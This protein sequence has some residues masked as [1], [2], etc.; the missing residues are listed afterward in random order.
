MLKVA[1]IILLMTGSIGMGLVLKKEAGNHL[2]ELYRFR[3]ILQMLQNEILYH[4]SPLPEACRRI[5][6]SLK[7][8]YR[9]AFFRIHD[10]MTGHC[11]ENFLQI[12]QKHM[13]ACLKAVKVSPEEKDILLDLG[14]CTAYSDE[15]AQAEAMNLYMHRLDLAA[16]RLEKNL[17]QKEK[18]IMSMSVMGGL[19]LTVILL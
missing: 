17:E 7:D 8:P 1:G 11:G 12:W 16:D 2:Q 6:S 3:T 13:S 5:G 18:L 19:L 10:E 4:K 9:S 15:R 14:S